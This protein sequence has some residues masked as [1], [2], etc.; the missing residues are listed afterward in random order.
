MIIGISGKK[1]HGKNL[2]ASIIQYLT[3]EHKLDKTYEQWLELNENKKQKDTILYLKWETK[4]FADKLK[5]IVCMLIGCSREELEDQKFKETPL[6][7]E[8]R[9]YYLRQKRNNE[10]YIKVSKIFINKESLEEYFNDF[11]IVVRKHSEIFTEILTPRLLL[12]LLGT[13]CGREIIHPN[14]WVNALMS[15]YKYE[16]T[17]TERVLNRGLNYGDVGWQLGRLPNWIITDVRFPNEAK[18]VKD[19]E[20]ILIRINRPS[21]DSIDNHLSEIALDTYNNFDEVITNDGSVES[22]IDKIKQILIKYKI[23]N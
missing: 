10:Q 18:A 20:G 5:H 4:S 12:Q 14:I 22:L 7:E 21:I 3:D 1:Q 23:L 16:H 2:V 11:P 9:V 6:G 15:E 13:E 8:W 17:I 19:K